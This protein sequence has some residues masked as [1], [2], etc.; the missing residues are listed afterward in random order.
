MKNPS[1][2]NIS[3]KIKTMLFVNTALT[4]ASTILTILYII[5]YFLYLDFL[6]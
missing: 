4:I 1:N 6:V 5:I 2:I 3:K